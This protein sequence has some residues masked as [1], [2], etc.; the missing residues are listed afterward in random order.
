MLVVLMQEEIANSYYT[1]EICSL[2]IPIATMKLVT[3]YS[4]HLTVR[5]PPKSLQITKLGV[6][7]RAGFEPGS[8]SR[9]IVCCSLTSE[10]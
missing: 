1:P 6:G 9:L 3:S 4:H 8:A 7:E 2:F 10:Y 5:E